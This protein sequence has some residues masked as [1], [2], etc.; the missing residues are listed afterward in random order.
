MKDYIL[1]FGGCGW[2][3]THKQREDLSFSDIPEM[4]M[5]GGKAANQAVAA[6]RCGYQVKIVSI[7]G[8]DLAGYKII[9]N[10]KENDVDTSAVKMI[11]GIKSD[12][13]HIYVSM[14]GDND[15][16]RSREAIDKFSPQ[17]VVENA[18]LIKNAEFVVTQSK[19]PREVL[20]ELIEFCYQNQVKLVLT[21]CPA[22]GLEV[23]NPENKSLLEKVTFITANAEEAKIVTGKKTI[24]EALEILPNMIAT[25]GAEGVYFMEE[26]EIV[27][28]PAITP[29]EILDTTGAGDTFCGNFIARLCQGETKREAIAYGV[30]AS[31]LKLE[32]YGAQ[33]GMPYSYEILNLKEKE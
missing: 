25:A 2:D 3:F 27:N 32:K 26:G 6:A 19:L 30:K 24:K 1:V 21:P 11:K 31:T 12:S 14:Q 8:D 29:R 9:Q 23:S 33:P 16:K 10:L 28:I 22:K 4:E 15:I 17:L 7:V 13:S 20:I 5:P 18:E